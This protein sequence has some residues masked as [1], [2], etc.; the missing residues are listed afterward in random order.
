VAAARACAA[1]IRRLADATE[2]GFGNL[3]FAVQACTPPGGPFFPSGYHDEGPPRFGLALEA[4]D[5][6]VQAFAG[7]TL[8]ACRDRLIFTLEEV[9][10]RLKAVADQLVAGGPRFAGIDLTLAPFPMTE[11]SIVHALERLGV[12][13]GGPGSLAAVAVLAD[14][15]RRVDL[16]RCGFSGV[17]LPLLEDNVLAER[18][19][20]G[21]VALETLLLASTVC[22][23]GLDTIPLPGDVTEAQV[24]GLLLDVAALAVVLD[25]PL[26]ARLMPTPGLAKGERTRFD[27]PYFA[28]STTAEVRAD[29]PT[30]PLA[31]AAFLDLRHRRDRL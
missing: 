24:T 18:H 3:R 2:H 23:T 19:A 28:S 5:L 7:P 14:A 13:F 27:F 30:A 15:L 9:G 20:D 11:R 6:A 31:E 16:P 1:A 26:T 4:A 25:K 12:R 8:A 29:G 21:L 17:M 22:G 10:L